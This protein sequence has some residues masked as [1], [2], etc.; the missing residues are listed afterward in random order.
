MLTDEQTDRAVGAVLG[1]AVADALGAAYEFDRVV[2]GPGEHAQ[3]LGG[4]IGSFEKGEWTDDTTMAWCILDAT[5]AGLDLRADEGL[6]VVARNFREWS[7]SGPKDI[8]NQTARVLGT[9][10][11]DPTAATLFHVSSELD[12]MTRHTGGNGSLMRTAPV[13]LRYLD[14]PAALVDAADKV[15]RLTHWDE[16]ARSGCALWSLAIRHAI[17]EADL[18]VRSGLA[19]LGES[20][21]AYWSERL[22]EAEQQPPE[23]FNPNGWVVTALQAAWAAIAQT[24]QRNH[25]VEALDTAIRIG[26]D[27]DTV[28]AIAGALL[29]ARWGASAIP[30]EWR[31]ISHGYPGLSGDMLV[32]LALD[33][34]AAGLR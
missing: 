31:R 13:P 21:A 4:G 11:P 22:D 26:N 25:Y 9:A 10:G 34:V 30:E 24:P 3:M 28:A 23:T 16:H 5:A 8:G 27:T 17:L 6:D 32:T 7:E 29:G 33:T 1:S 12:K 18:D 19:Y 2:L 20:E 15:S 14:D